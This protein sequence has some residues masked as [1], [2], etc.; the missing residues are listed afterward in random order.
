[1]HLCDKDIRALLDQFNFVPEEGCSKFD[2]DQQVQAASV[3]L[4]LGM[5]FW[6]SHRNYTVDLRRSRLLEVQPRR[7]YRRLLLNPSDAILLKP[8]EMLL[9]R[10]AEEFSIPNGFTAEV[11]GRSSF[12]RLGLMVTLA[13]GISPGWRGR[14]PLQLINMG[15]NSIKLVPGLPIC[16]IRITRMTGPAER[17]YDSPLLES[18][19]M[20]DDGGP[21]YWWKDKRIKLLHETLSQRSIEI[22]IQQQ[23]DRIIGDSE[24]EVIERLESFV[25]NQKLADLQDANSILDGFAVTEDRRRTL[26]RWG[27]NV[28]RGLFTVTISASLWLLNRPFHNWYYLVWFI[29]AVLALVSLYAF[30]TEVGDHFGSVELRKKIRQ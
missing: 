6:R 16:Q 30:R 17:A 24:P 13:G 21:S 26:R 10:T 29:A 14:A 25:A 12:A 9:A 8:H 4:R 22:N 2:P 19:Y 18:K 28:A 11:F 1:M 3:D 15:T 23:V 7:Y 5:V 27:I 20:H